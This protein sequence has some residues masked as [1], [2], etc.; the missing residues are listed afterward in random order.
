MSEQLSVELRDS[1]MLRHGSGEG[2]QNIFAVAY[3]LK[4]NKFGT[5]KTEQSGEK[6]L[7]QV[8]DQDPSGH[9]DRALEFLSGDGRTFQKN[10]HLCITPP[11]RPLW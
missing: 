7:G 11:I 4:W 1:I 2:Y 9:S 3:I 10:N 8:G 6:G 5:T